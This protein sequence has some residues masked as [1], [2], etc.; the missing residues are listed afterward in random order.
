MDGSNV[1]KYVIVIQKHISHDNARHLHSS[2]LEYTLVCSRWR[3]FALG[4]KKNAKN[5][6]FLFAEQKNQESAAHRDFLCVRS[7]SSGGGFRKSNKI[8][9]AWLLE[10]S[11][12]VIYYCCAREERGGWGGGGAQEEKQHQV[13]EETK[14]SLLYKFL[15]FSPEP[16][17]LE[18]E[19]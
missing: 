15:S 9:T 13:Y 16:C 6:R 3:I 18:D 4:R 1:H 8:C 12:W 11:C 14:D 10:I 5:R 7:S 2:H 17:M 19:M